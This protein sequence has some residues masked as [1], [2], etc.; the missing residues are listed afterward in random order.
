MRSPAAGRSR[1]RSP[2]RPGNREAA[3]APP[4]RS[5]RAS[6]GPR[7][8]DRHSDF[9]RR[10]D[11]VLSTHGEKSRNPPTDKSFTTAVAPDTLAPPHCPPPS[12][13]DRV[14]AQ[15]S[16]MCKKVI[17]CGRRVCTP[18]PRLFQGGISSR[19]LRMAVTSR[20]SSGK[21][22]S[23]ASRSACR[24]APERD[25]HVGRVRGGV[26]KPRRL[27]HP[28]AELLH[29]SSVTRVSREEF[30]RATAAT[31]LHPPPELQCCVWIVPCL[32]HEQQADVIGFG[33]L[34]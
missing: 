21:K 31:L 11:D 13:R 12:G 28:L 29:A 7:C 16:F 6:T 4:P 32:R 3:V 1:C 5:R 9:A 30:R 20:A 25:A 18:I 27:R 2:S 19:T 23:P 8:S 14:Q 33:L 10:R 15:T 17:C 34:R 26:V 24:S 22:F